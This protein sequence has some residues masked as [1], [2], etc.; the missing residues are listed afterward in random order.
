MSDGNGG[1]DTSTLTI[2]VTNVNTAP[3][4]GNESV[5]TPEGTVA[6]G[7][8]LDN[9]SDV[10]G[11]TPVVTGFT[12]GETNYA[13]GATATFDGVGTLTI[14][15]NGA[16]VFTPVANYNGPVP[17]AT[18]TVSD[19]NG[20]TD[21]STLTIAVTPVND[22]SV[23][24]ADTNSVA[25]DT[26]ATGNVL[27]N[28]SDVDNTLH[29]ASF[30]INGV[31]G[32]FT[33]GSTAAT[34]AGVGAITIAANGDYSFTPVANWNG[35]VPQVTYTTDTGSSSTLDITVT[36]VNDASVLV[37]DTNSVAEDT[38]ATGNVLTNDSDVDNTLHVASFT[39]NGVVG[40][41]TV[42]STAATI[43]GVG[44]IT[45]AANGDY[46]FT[47]VANWNG[48]VPQVTYTTDT[49]SSSTLDITVTPV[50]DPPLAA[51]DSYS[52]S[53]NTTL[54]VDVAAGLL[55][56]DTDVDGNTLTVS[57]HGNPSHGTLVQNPDGSFGYTPNADYT[58]SDS[59]SYT[60]SD[61]HGGT[62]T[63]TVNLTINQDADKFVIGSAGADTTGSSDTFTEGTGS[64]IVTGNGG[65]D[66]LVGDPGG[67]IMQAGATANIALVLDIS[68]R[69]IAALLLAILPSHAFRR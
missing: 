46:S 28:D 33:V 58:G 50:N 51:N 8:V 54:T 43:A 52:L 37:A 26:Q 59:F 27:T 22:A 23:L 57:A 25:E 69:W 10:D 19:G 41:F 21:T 67:S 5:T 35:T 68:K 62:S 32:T 11:G 18:Y 13:A 42:G 1:T 4:D 60:I 14:G 45:I 15:A 12:V 34:I 47:P 29:V 6:S 55:H 61:G 2:A 56:N 39:I 16:Y 24:V 17:V 48:T 40:T 7:N 36:P 53:E 65:N 30:T 31:V 20:G 44:A 49:G 3:V 38:Q 66:V 64:G 9:S 63:A